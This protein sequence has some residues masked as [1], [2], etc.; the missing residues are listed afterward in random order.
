MIA[1]D[2][3]SGDAQLHIKDAHGGHVTAMCMGSPDTAW[4]C[5]SGGQDGML[6]AWDFR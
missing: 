5:L 1:W 3:Q 6:V 4:D 2:L